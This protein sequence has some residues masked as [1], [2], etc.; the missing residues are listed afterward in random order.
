MD[1]PKAFWLIAV[2]ALLGFVVLACVIA[3]AMGI[4]HDIV[5]RMGQRHAEWTIESRIKQLQYFAFYSY[6][7]PASLYNRSCWPKP[8]PIAIAK[9][10]NVDEYR[11]LECSQRR[12]LPRP[13]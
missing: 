6:N 4:L 11:R 2:N 1:D 7:A 3:M 5:V 13:P 12:D 10:S 9:R 8:G